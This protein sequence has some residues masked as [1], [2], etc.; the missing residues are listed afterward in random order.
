M[1]IERLLP[2]VRELARSGFGYE[3]VMVKLRI[4]PRNVHV[5]RREVLG[6]SNVH[7]QRESESEIGRHGSLPQLRPRLVS[8]KAG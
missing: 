2:Q 4:H 5:V 8:T 1:I 3:D 6:M 7:H